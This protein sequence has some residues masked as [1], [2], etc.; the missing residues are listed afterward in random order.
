MSL[1]KASLNLVL[2]TPHIYGNTVALSEK[3]TQLI[4]QDLPFLDPYRLV[5]SHHCLKNVLETCSKRTCST[6]FPGHQIL[7]AI[8]IFKITMSPEA[9]FRLYCLLCKPEFLLSGYL[10]ILA[11]EKMSLHS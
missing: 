10:K 2:V 3:A 4:R 11:R 5:L 1:S 8:F 6:F 9:Y 7:L